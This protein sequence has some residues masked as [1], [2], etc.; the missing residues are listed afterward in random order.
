MSMYRRLAPFGVVVVAVASAGACSSSSGGG[1]G[2]GT[3][4]SGSEAA[5]EAGADVTADT[6]NGGDS[7]PQQDASEG[8]STTDSPAEATVGDGGPC[9]PSSLGSSL[10]LWLEG[11]MGLTSAGTPAT[12]TWTDQSSAK[13]NATSSTQANPPTIDSAVVNGHSAL[14]FDGT[15]SLFVPDATTL[16][17]G[18]DSFAVMLVMSDATDTADAA[19]GTGFTIVSKLAAMAGSSVG[20]ALQLVPGGLQATDYESKFITANTTALGDA[21]F[22]VVGMVRSGGVLQVR[23]D[24]A[25]AASGTFGTSISAPSQALTFGVSSLLSPP[26]YAGDIA[27]VVAVHPAPADPTCLEG[28]LKAKY[29]L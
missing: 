20:L 9:D 29:G 6:G 11:D 27:E 25:M 17:W 14:K 13:N 10:V 1:S 2:G 7:G 22:H 15:N 5:I 12:V 23:I 18:T 21:K 4:D 24:G 3:P 26:A 28:H 16:Q 19:A 8:G